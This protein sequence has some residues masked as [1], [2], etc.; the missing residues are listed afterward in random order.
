MADEPQ[1][2][3]R[4]NQARQRASSAG[5]WAAANPYVGD[6]GPTFN[7]EA[8]EEAGPTPLHVLEIAWEPARVKTILRGQGLLTHEAIGVGRE[9]WTWRDGELE[10][11]SEPL[12][13][14][15]N[16]F[17][18]TRAAAAVSDE[19]T[20]GA[21]AFEYAFRSIKERTEVLRARQAA[22]RRAKEPVVRPVTGYNA[23]GERVSP[24]EVNWEV[25]E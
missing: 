3:L 13:N 2:D 19:L 17:P 20:V 6:S 9:D 14:T 25:Q 23:D 11:I 10:A 24:G 5:S 8:A 16:K 21:V 18:V 22:A 1:P 4:A 15:L 12:A 7:A